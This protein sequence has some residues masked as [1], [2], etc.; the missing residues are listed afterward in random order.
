MEEDH[1][2]IEEFRGTGDL[3]ALDRL[4]QRHID[5]V[6][7][8]VYTMVRNHADK[9]DVVQEVFIRA[10]RALDKFD[11]RANFSTWLH[12]IALNTARTHLRR[13][14]RSPEQG[15]G[16]LPPAAAA[17]ADSPHAALS[18]R[19][20]KQQIEAA[21]DD[22]SDKLRAAVVLLILQQRGVTEAAAMEQCSTATMY[23]R[24]HQARR[25]LKTKLGDY[26]P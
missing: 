21:L 9:D 13:R 12:R 20:L 19:E 14:G 17:D 5:S 10:F 3:S 22:L 26:L 11:G 25:K 7:A 24:L 1:V 2:L 4:V 15:S 16:D 8:T 23:W 6:R 18:G